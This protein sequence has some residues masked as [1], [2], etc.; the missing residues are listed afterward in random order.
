[1]KHKRNENGFH[2]IVLLLVVIIIAVIG[3]A[4]WTVYNNNKSGNH[5][6][7]SKETTKGLNLVAGEQVD[8]QGCTG[9]GSV[10]F[11]TSPM[12]PQDIGSIL[13]YGG[14]V[15][16]HVTPIDHMYFS[17][18][19]FNSPRDTY[20]VRAMA[21]GL[22]T[23]IGE[24]TQQVT[25]VNNGAP[26]K[27]EYQ[28]KFW[29][30]CDFASYYDLITSLSPRLKAE[31]DTHKNNGGYAGLQ[32]KVK[33]GEVVGR[34]GGQTLDFAVYDYK[35]ILPGFIVPEHYLAESW[36]VHVVNPF[37]YFKE[38]VRSQLLALDPRQAPPR[39]GKLDYDKDGKLVG[40]WFKEGNN[41]FA[42]TNGQVT[43]PWRAHLSFVYDSID[44][45]TLTI[46]I[47]DYGGQSEQFFVKSNS[48]D[49]ADIS[50]SSGLVKYELTQRSYYRSSTGQ[51]WDNMH[52]FTDIVA[53]PGPV[54]Q[55]VALAQM[56][57]DRKLKFEAS[58]GKTAT[59]VTG[60]DSKAIIYER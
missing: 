6:N 4:G 17:P 44:P 47:G 54:T 8:N 59:Q 15:G 9:T 12:A 7:G 11:G 2:H 16:A 51:N 25:D 22:I 13:P 46:S 26:K 56:T 14:M 5:K 39:E 36:K 37:S 21:D 27:A 53:R 30:S 31:F 20:E 23:A 18:I 3:F 1:M 35:K 28:I 57:S 45:S 34:I 19:V 43:S 40:T 33:E 48:P 58:P 55:G 29:Y 50:T 32:I 42:P 38:P 10:Q 24:R 49:P 60:F 41:G 52:V